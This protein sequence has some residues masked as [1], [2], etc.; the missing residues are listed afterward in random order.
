[1][2]TLSVVGK[3]LPRVDAREKVTG[4]AAYSTDVQLPGMLHGLLLRSPFPHA[5][6]TRLDASEAERLPG[7]RAVVT[8]RD[9]PGIRLGSLVKDDFVLARDRVRFVGD[10]VAA[11][12]AEDLE[13]AARALDLIRIDWEELPAVFAAEEA[14]EEGAPR[15]HEE[16]I[17]PP[18]HPLTHDPARNVGVRI[19]I[20]K[21]DVE[22][23][24][25]KADHVF[26]NRF[27]TK[28]V[29]Q[30]YLEPN[31][32]VAFWD[33]HGKLTAYAS[34]MYTSGLQKGLS[35][36]F[37]IPLS[38]VRVIGTT[39]GGAFGGKISFQPLHAITALL[40]RKAGAPV[41]LANSGEEEFT[42][43]RPRVSTVIEV[44]T[45]VR[46]DGRLLGRR[47]RFV[48]DCGAY[49]HTAAPMLILLSARSDSLYRIG[50]IETDASMVY[51]NK[52]PIGAYRGYGN[53]QMTFAFESEL[54][55]IADA[56]GIDPAELRLRNATQAGDTT[57]HGW[58]VMSCG[59]SEAIESVANGS[60]WSH[61]TPM[62][63][64]NRTSS[65]GESLRGFGMACMI[66]ESDDRQTE[67]FSGSVATLTLREDGRA[68]IVTGE[69][70]YGQG[71]RTVYAQIAAEVL[72]LSSEDVDQ[73]PIDTDFTPYTLGPWG[74][75]LTLSGGNAVRLAAEDARAQAIAEAS[76]ILEVSEKD[77][78]LREGHVSVRAAPEKRISLGEV[79][80]SRIHKRNG[81]P[82]IGRGVEEPDTTPLDPTKQTN[83]SSAYSFAAQVAEV[84]VNPK[85]GQVKVLHL[86]TGNDAG[87]PINPLALRG[88]IEGGVLQGLG[89][90]LFEE[91][92]YEDGKILNPGFLYSGI[93]LASEVPPIDCA[94]VGSGDPYGPFGAKGGGELGLTPVPAAVANA[95]QNACGVRLR[96]LPLTPEKVLKALRHPQRRRPGSRRGSPPAQP[97][98]A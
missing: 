90:A 12:A 51:T 94:F 79:V 9:V 31:C 76:R 64:T 91:V 25:A 60:G 95:V 11:V 4:A 89:Q 43:G 1:M 70:E 96:S 13:T 38:K 85:T 73:G 33:A 8:G 66:H 68:F 71:S 54:E 92:R 35:N 34:S 77:L 15:I 6:I 37:G 17:L 75:R 93:P 52:T 49:I 72:G 22:G 50:A 88:Q 42:A 14:L 26:E 44:Q 29:H 83:P 81:S 21:G 3:P 63:G 24:F 41:R 65:G 67:R 20:R 47:T 62:A 10:E 97:E 56:L 7:V 5:R 87:T 55:G 2:N 46:D 80:K 39:V 23:A 98:E 59:L 61:R 32:V 18:V 58:K 28:I 74:S 40:A 53:P 82:I 84:E 30:G 27:E 16:E 57:V 86:Y 69:S 19:E 48:G 45:A 36:V 78:T